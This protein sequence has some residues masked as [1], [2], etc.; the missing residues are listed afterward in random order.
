MSQTLSQKAKEFAYKAHEGQKR[1]GGLPYITHP[2]GVV[3]ILQEYGVSDDTV[4]SIAW[5]HDILEDTDTKYEDLEKEFGKDVANRVYLLTRN[6]DREEY[7]LR[8]KSSDL[9]TKIIKIADTL[10]NVQNPYLMR[11]LSEIGIK[12]KI[13]DCEEFYIPLAMQVCPV[14]G[15]KL[16]ESIDNYLKIFG[17]Y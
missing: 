3:R 10:H 17:R 15:Y 14:M 12:R 9:I 5:V 6:V 13:D 16:K 7:K 2:E 1:K 8:I 4:L 11:H